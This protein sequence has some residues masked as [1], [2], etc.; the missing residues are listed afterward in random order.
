MAIEWNASYETGEARI[1]GQHRNLFDYVN[2]LERLLESTPPGSPPNREEVD[3]LLAFLES[4][5]NTHFAY[6]ELCMTLRG[7][8]IARKNKEAHDRFLALYADFTQQHKARGG[9]SVEMLR[10][11]HGTLKNWLVGHICNIDVQ[12]RGHTPVGTA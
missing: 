9:A 3:N 8:P 5:V 7:C 11:L 6:E 12:L 1:D 10:E 4:Y 2:R